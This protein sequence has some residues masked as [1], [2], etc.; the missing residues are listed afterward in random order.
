[1][2]TFAVVAACL[3]AACS[4]S[5]DNLSEFSGTVETR[6]IQAGSK[7]GGRV[8]EV[9]VVEGATVRGGSPLVRFD[10]SE[11]EASRRQLEARVE[12]ANAEAAKLRRGFRPEESEQAEANARRERA[13][14]DALKKGP[15]TQ[16]IEQAEAELSASQADAVNAE[17]SYDRIAALHKSGDVSSQAS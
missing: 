6:E 1:M 15:R 8:A 17:K 5:P 4:R 10:V 9:F 14:L 3:A 2:R 13:A 11:L 7:V 12:Q 16:E